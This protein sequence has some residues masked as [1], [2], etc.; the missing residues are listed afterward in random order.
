VFD[1]LDA[2]LDQRAQLVEEAG[3][4]GPQFLRDEL[5]RRLELARVG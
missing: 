3:A 5:A 1:G 2:P 4:V